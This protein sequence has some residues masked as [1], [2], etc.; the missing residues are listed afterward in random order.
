MQVI[1]QRRSNRSTSSNN[2]WSHSCLTVSLSRH[3]NEQDTFYYS[4]LFK[5]SLNAALSC[6]YGYTTDVLF[7]PDLR[8][9][10]DLRQE[11]T[12]SY[13]GDAC[14]L[15]IPVP[16]SDCA[17]KG[18]LLFLPKTTLGHQGM[19][20]NF[21]RIDKFLP[22]EGFQSSLETPIILYSTVT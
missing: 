13:K 11:L 19:T 7:I 17:I 12:R 16:C 21:T 3:I 14:Y 20:S 1:R 2:R 4:L 8:S 9:I 22:K 5:S 6:L 10:S 15:R 18:H